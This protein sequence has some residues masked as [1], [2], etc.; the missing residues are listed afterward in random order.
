MARHLLTLGTRLG[1]VPASKQLTECS[2]HNLTFQLLRQTKGAAF[3]AKIDIEAAFDSLSQIAVALALPT[4]G[5]AQCAVSPPVWYS[6]GTVP[7]CVLVAEFSDSGKPG[8]FRVNF[9]TIRLVYSTIR[10]PVSPE[11]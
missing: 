10:E 9:I 8:F 1:V 4:R 6:G 5:G 3:A 7:I 2:R 11:P